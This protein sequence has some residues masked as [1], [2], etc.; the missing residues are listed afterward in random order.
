MN[1][2]VIDYNKSTEKIKIFLCFPL[3]FTIFLDF[4]DS[5]VDGQSPVVPQWLCV[6]EVVTNF[7]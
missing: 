5:Q 4:S 7:I 6:Q 1:V 2:L 3:I